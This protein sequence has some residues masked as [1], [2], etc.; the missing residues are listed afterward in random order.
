MLCITLFK[1]QKAI[2]NRA[3]NNPLVYSI[4]GCGEAIIMSQPM[5]DVS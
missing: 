5:Y 3:D 2:E 4:Q 1:T